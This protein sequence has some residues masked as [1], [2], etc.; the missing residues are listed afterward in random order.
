M[1]RHL[2]DEYILSEASNEDILRPRGR[3]RCCKAN[4][5]PNLGVYKYLTQTP[6]IWSEA[7]PPVENKHPRNEN[8]EGGGA[9]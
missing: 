8:V 1:Y 6:Q 9:V 5:V 7:A 3:P 2:S 4:N